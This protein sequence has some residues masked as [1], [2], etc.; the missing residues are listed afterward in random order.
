VSCLLHQG[1]TVHLFRGFQI[2]CVGRDHQTLFWLVSQKLDG[3]VVDRRVGL[4][5]AKKLAGE[6]QVEVEAGGFGDV[7]LEACC[8]VGE[9]DALMTFLD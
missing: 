6:Q 7:D 5:Q 2:I 1:M 9:D 8:A 4:G 3:F